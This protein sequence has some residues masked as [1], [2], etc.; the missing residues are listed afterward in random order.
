VWQSPAVTRQALPKCIA[1]PNFA[2]IGQTVAEIW[3]Y[4]DFSR[5]RPQPY[6][7]IWDFYI[8]EILSIG[9]VNRVKMRRRGKFCGDQTSRC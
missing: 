7:A 8:F 1:A 6:S 3:R 2:V 5:W 9:G 4:V